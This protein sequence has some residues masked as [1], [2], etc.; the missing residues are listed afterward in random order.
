MKKRTPFVIK[1]IIKFMAIALLVALAV[2]CVS[3][4]KKDRI[5]ISELSIE[6]LE[7]SLE[8]CEY[9][10]LELSLNGKSKEQ[11][12]IEYIMSNSHIKKY[13]AGTVDYYIDQQK[14]QFSYYAKMADMSYE[15]MLDTLG[16]DTFTMQAEARRLV[17]QDV[18]LA[19]IQR[20]E[21]IELSE[22]DKSAY[23]DRYAEL[24][25]ERYGY[26]PNYVREELSELVYESMLYDKT[27]EFLIIN[28]S[29]VEDSAEGESAAE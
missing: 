5:A 27:V 8:L 20:R 29:F 16:E 7:E 3:C 14:K 6:E 17:K 18:I 26:E 10:G 12:L 28:N 13:P 11:V 25:A 4:V 2:F 19:L 9:K 23:F 21:G 24:Y 15:D 1:S 22:G